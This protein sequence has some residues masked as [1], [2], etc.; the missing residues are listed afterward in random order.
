M[1][2]IIRPV[3]G[4][5]D[6]YPESMMIRRWIISAM[7]NCSRKFGYQE[8][9]APCL[10]TIDLYAAKSG[11]E[12]VKEQSFVFPDRGGDLIALRP[13]LTPSLARMVASKQ[14]ELFFPLRWYSF[15]PFWRYERPQKGRSREFFQWNIDQIGSNSINSD[16][17]IVAVA[18]DFF[19]Q[20]GLSSEK[21]KIYINDRRLM[22]KS[23]KSLG[24]SP[25]LS[26]S[27]VKLIDRVDKLEKDKWE[28]FAQDLGL[29]SEQVGRLED[30]LFKQ[31][32]WKE[33]EELV[34]FFQVC[35]WLGI[36]D[37]VEF[38]PKVVRGLDYYTGIVFEG[39]D[40]GRHYRAI[41]GGGHYDNLV[42]DVGG[43]P[44]PGVG[45][46]MG[47]VVIEILL[48]DLGCIPPN[49]SSSSRIMVT[50][51]DESCLEYSFRLSSELR[52]KEI[53]VLTFPTYEKLS[54][55][56]KYADKIGVNY[57]L[58]IGPDEIQKNIITIKDLKTQEQCTVSDYLI[59]DEIKRLL[60]KAPTLC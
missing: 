47:D 18:V 40:V 60:D 14:N 29:T 49:I 32:L 4:T 59:V 41:F 42:A 26:E 44:L 48:R 2:S 50:V 20:V 3:K 53:D 39:R 54:K 56:L 34:S 55:Q 36:Q 52:D 16:A 12:L 30:L 23:I 6:F 10:E 46:A 43:N 11:D 35:N 7:H 38:D 13:E 21:V 45:F 8:Y 1:N 17:E 58:I 25:E 22:E 27:V 31:D 9:D 24:I 19:K 33:S 51:F 15:G 57:V 5:R 28:E 37:Y